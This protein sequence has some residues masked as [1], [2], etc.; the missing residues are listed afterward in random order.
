MISRLFEKF[1]RKPELHFLHI[2]KTGGSAIKLALQGN[3]R[4]RHYSVHLHGH[5]TK[6]IDI[7]EGQKIFFFLRDPITK[8][9]SGFY[10]RQR[11]GQPKYNIEWNKMEEKVFHTFNT[12]NE[13]AAALGNTS[14]SNHDLAIIAMDAIRHL[15]SYYTWFVDL[16]YFKSRIDDIFF[17]GFQENLDDSFE[18]LKKNLYLPVNLAL[19]K[20]DIGAHRNPGH[21]DKSLNDEATVAL[22][23]WYASDIE[24]VA[25]CKELMSNRAA[26]Q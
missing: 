10:S 19:P 12:P 17:I 24:F 23:K 5:G 14:S 2:G 21:L 20:D 6:L 4:T 25:F 18:E 15:A 26:G 11:K 1:K 22:R 7:P 3:L 8:F 16:E 9:V 13:L